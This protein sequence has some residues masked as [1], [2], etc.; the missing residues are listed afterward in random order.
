MKSRQNPICHSCQEEFT[1]DPRNARHQKFCTKPECR[2]ASKKASNLAWLAKPEN[3]NYHSGPLAVARVQAAQ[4]LHPE[5][6]AR[7]K[8]KRQLALQD[9][10]PAQVPE[11]KQES[12]NLPVAA[13]PALQDV[14]TVQPFVFIGLMAHF[15]GITLQ[16]DIAKI[17]QVL[18]ELGQ[19]IMQGSHCD[20]PAKTSHSPGTAANLAAKVQLGRSAAGTG[21]PP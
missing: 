19:D 12:P 16:D 21:A 6:R 13:A 15:F 3:T 8:A 4:K 18:Q 9:V 14:L 5:Y 2:K 11:F 10:L 17:S 1:P 20:E 7:E